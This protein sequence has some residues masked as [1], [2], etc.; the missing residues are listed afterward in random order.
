[1]P[2]TAHIIPDILLGIFYLCMWDKQDI[3]KRQYQNAVIYYVTAQ[4]NENF[5]LTAAEA[6]NHALNETF[7][8]I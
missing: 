5:I 6:S 4:K 2:G 3:S 7:W 1:M 8:D